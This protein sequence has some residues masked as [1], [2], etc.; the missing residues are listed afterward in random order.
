MAQAM[1]QTLAGDMLQISEDKLEALQQSLRG[2]LC[3]PGETG[4]DEACSLWNAMIDRRPGMVI[5]CAGAADVMLAVN[6]ARAQELL[7][8]W[9]WPQHRRQGQL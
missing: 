2:Q 1:L 3:L 8:A 6:F 7:L 5:R 9:R 4:Y